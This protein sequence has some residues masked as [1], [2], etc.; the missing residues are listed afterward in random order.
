MMA[1][2][3][4]DKLFTSA[5]SAVV[6]STVLTRCRLVAT[7]IWPLVRGAMS[8]NAITSGVDKIT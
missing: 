2:G 5:P 1:H 8:R 3:M 4:R 6:I 7:S